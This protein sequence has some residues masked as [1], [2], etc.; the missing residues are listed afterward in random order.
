MKFEIRPTDDVSSIISVLNEEDQKIFND[1]R[2]E[3][4]DTW[5]KN[6]V[7]RTETEARISVL[8][9]AKHPTNASKYWQSVKEQNSMFEAIMA[10][11]FQLRRLEVKKLRLEK[12]LSECEDEFRLMEIQIEQDELMYTRAN[13]EKTVKDRI[14]EIDMWSRIK[15]ELNDGSF[16][17]KDVNEHQLESY[18]HILENR[19]RA[20]SP[21][22]TDGERL[23]AVGPW[24]TVKKYQAAGNKQLDSRNG[25]TIIQ[26]TLGTTEGSRKL[27]E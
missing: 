15:K 21:N 12:E 23:N 26:S 16:N 10:S 11:S 27:S 4:T 3:L 6:Q 22:A 5:T 25:G 17:T 24:N 20:L 2:D 8:N 1:L 9:D 13:I 14:R 7:F 19:V 18:K